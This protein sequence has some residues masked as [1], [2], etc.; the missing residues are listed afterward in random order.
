M[1]F[2]Q[3]QATSIVAVEVTGVA[4]GSG[5]AVVEVLANDPSSSQWLTVNI[6]QLTQACGLPV[7]TIYLE[8]L[9]VE[10]TESS[11]SYPIPKDPVTV[12]SSPK[13]QQYYILASVKM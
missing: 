4:R 6:P 2:Y 7:E 11:L 8:E 1:K 3:W 10:E 12:V 5:S 13:S 9:K